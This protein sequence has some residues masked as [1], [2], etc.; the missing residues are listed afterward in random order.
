MT[1][2][3]T[4]VGLETVGVLVAHVGKMLP[5]LNSRPE[6]LPRQYAA[7][8]LAKYTRLLD[9][10]M[11]LRDAGFPD[12][13]GLGLRSLLECWYLGMLLLFSPSE[14]MTTIG[15][16]HVHQFKQL[17]A[18]WGD[19]SLAWDDIDVGTKPKCINWSDLSKRVGERPLG[20]FAWP[21]SGYHRYSDEDGWSVPSYVRARVIVDAVAIDGGHQ[22]IPP[23]APPVTGIVCPVT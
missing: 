13:I 1:D 2:R 3:E 21:G 11:Q 23:R 10:M 14:A 20:L 22:L 16:G 5:Y 6:L 19:V 15:S 7:A 9:A 18:S 8:C 17:D 4:E 12:V